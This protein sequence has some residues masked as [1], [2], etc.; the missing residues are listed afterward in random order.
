[1]KLAFK[2]DSS[3]GVANANFV[4]VIKAVRAVTGFGLK[5]AKELSESMRASNDGA[6]FFVDSFPQYAANDSVKAEAIAELKMYGVSISV[7]GDNTQHF[8]KELKE[9]VCAMI[10]AGETSL[11]KDVL[12]VVEKWENL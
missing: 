8:I 5:E 12:S 1:M 2:V 4:K 7:G 9:S 11:A 6:V 3:I 10:M